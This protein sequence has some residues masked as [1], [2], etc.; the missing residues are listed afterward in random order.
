MNEELQPKKKIHQK[1]TISSWIPQKADFSPPKVSPFFFF[2]KRDFTNKWKQFTNSKFLICFNI[3]N[4]PKRTH[5]KKRT[6]SKA[7]LSSSTNSVWNFKMLKLPESYLSKNSIFSVTNVHVF[8]SYHERWQK[9]ASF[10]IQD[11]IF[12]NEYR[13][14]K[15]KSNKIQSNWLFLPKKQ[16]QKKA[17]WKNSIFCQTPNQL[18]NVAS[19][20]NLQLKCH[21]RSSPRQTILCRCGPVWWIILLDRSENSDRGKH[22]NAGMNFQIGLKNLKKC[23]APPPPPPLNIAIEYM[24]SFQ[25]HFLSKESVS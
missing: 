14:C 12:T 22:D 17:F 23:I 2:L 21:R 18:G 24:I 20:P 9:T 16:Q 7:L 6:S 3:F 13:N 15:K 4:V 8:P 19:W 1:C 5:W 10:G 11:Y 25:G